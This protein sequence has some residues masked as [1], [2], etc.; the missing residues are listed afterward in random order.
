[1]NQRRAAEARAIIVLLAKT[2]PACFAVLECR[3][4]PL[5]ISIRTSLRNTLAGAVELHVSLANLRE[6]G[7]RRAAAQS[8]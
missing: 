1:M 2:Y 7:R 5:A 6:A 3:R 4:K 8:A